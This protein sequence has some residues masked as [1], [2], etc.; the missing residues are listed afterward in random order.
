MAEAMT[1]T[2]GAMVCSSEALMGDVRFRPEKNSSWFTPM[3]STPQASERRLSARPVILSCGATKYLM[4]AKN[5]AA[6]RMRSV[7]MPNGPM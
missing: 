3:P 4:T 5:S 2:M 6:P 1:T 7:T